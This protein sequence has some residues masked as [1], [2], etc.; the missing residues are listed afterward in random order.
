L[1]Y[2]VLIISVLIIV[3]IFVTKLSDNLGIPSLVLFMIVGMLAGT[4]GFGNI[5]FEDVGIAR[6]IGIISLVLIL[7]AGSLSI[8]WRDMKAVINYSVSLSTIGVAVTTILTGLFVHFVFGFDWRYALLLGAMVSSTDAAAVFSV[9]RAKDI[10]LKQNVR[11][12]LEVESCSNDPLAVFLTI[13]FIELIQIPD[14]SVMSV[15]WDFIN[16]FSLGLILG[17]SFG[18][19]MLFVINKINLPYDEL[20]PILAIVFSLL[21]YSAVTLIGGSGFLAVFI[22]SSYLGN[23]EFVQKKS[24]TRFFESLAQMGEILMFLTL[25]LLVFPSQLVTIIVPGLII[26]AVLIFLLRPI[27][28]FIS[29]MISKFSYKDKL[30]ISWVGLRGA[31]PIVLATF[32][33]TAGVAEANTLF[34]LVFFIVLSSVLIQGWSIPLAAKIFNVFDT[35]KESPKIGMEIKSSLKTNK[36]LIDFIVPHNSGIVDKSLAE[37]NLP[38]E[39]LITFVSREDE[40]FVP[41]G[42]T[43]LKEGDTLLILSDKDK[44]NEL[45]TVLNQKA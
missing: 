1:E 41:N 35:S 3:S 28:V 12:T 6:T 31:V 2:I 25:G 43:K 23:H 10:R 14:L 42:S 7:F 19:L 21:I 29:L 9:L 18:W 45:I 15:L 24:L 5:N 44:I 40:Y 13:L 4:D 26:S 36:E 8:K 17:L 30:F 32:P 34:N 37:L 27:G 33:L 20:Y 39:T 38:E 16:D 11:S 22:S